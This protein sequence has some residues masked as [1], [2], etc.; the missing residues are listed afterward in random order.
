MFQVAR[1]ATT[2]LYTLA[3]HM[4]SGVALDMSLFVTKLT[5]PRAGVLVTYTFLQPEGFA[6]TTDFALLLSVEPG[7]AEPGLAA[8]EHA[9]VQI[10]RD[11][12]RIYLAGQPLLGM[13]APL[14][15]QAF[16]KLLQQLHDILDDRAV[17]LQCLAGQPQA[18]LWVR[19]PGSCQRHEQ[20]RL[21]SREH[22]MSSG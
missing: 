19:V 15:H 22:S 9:S 21:A 6:Q 3:G 14:A 20:H 4:E 5:I 13:H 1:C 17:K 16:L 2:R 18:L 10:A 12:K 8:A 7:T 11:K